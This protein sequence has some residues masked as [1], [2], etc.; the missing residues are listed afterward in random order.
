MT[1]I[2]RQGQHSTERLRVALPAGLVLLALLYL[3]SRENFLLFYALAGSLVHNAISATCFRRHWCRRGG[4]GLAYLG[5]HGAISHGIRGRGGPHHLQG[6][7]RVRRGRR[8]PSHRR[9]GNLLHLLR[10]CVRLLEFRGPYLQVG[11]R[12][13]ATSV[14]VRVR[15]SAMAFALSARVSTTLRCSGRIGREAG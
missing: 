7:E 6:L 9:G 4:D 2:S 1:D 13:K 11:S 14:G 12:S 10:E 15:H 3:L 8:A 5:L